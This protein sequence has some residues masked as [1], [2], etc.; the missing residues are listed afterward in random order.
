MVADFWVSIQGIFSPVFGSVITTPF[1]SL[2]PSVPNPGNGASG[3]YVV[4]VSKIQESFASFN[5]CG[6]SHF[7]GIIF[8]TSGV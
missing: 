5:L 1:A 8:I 3:V 6:G 7:N 2:Q 4:F